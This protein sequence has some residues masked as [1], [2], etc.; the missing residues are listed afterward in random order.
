MKATLMVFAMLWV[1]LIA[2]SAAA[3]TLQLTLSG[4]VW[5]DLNG[6]GSRDPA[7]PGVAAIQVRLHGPSGSREALTDALGRYEFTGLQPG[8]YRVQVVGSLPVQEGAGPAWVATAP[9]RIVTGTIESTVQLT[10]SSVSLDFGLVSIL[11]FSRFV[12]QVTQNGAPLDNPTVEAIVAGRVCSFDFGIRPAGAAAN[13]YSIAVASAAFIPGCGTPGEAVSFRV[14]G[15]MANETAVWEPNRRM[16]DLT[17][18]TGTVAPTAPA[19]TVPAATATATPAVTSTPEIARLP[20]VG[21][22]ND[23]EGPKFGILIGVTLGVLGLA[24]VAAA[25]FTSA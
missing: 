6:N 3:E 25:R 4:I 16:L 12:G 21:S 10:T 8:S 9:Q 18:G 23:S 17:I 7:E 1:S 22:S 24:T 13:R 15:V 2:S 20:S 19:P 14:N 5:E 11:T